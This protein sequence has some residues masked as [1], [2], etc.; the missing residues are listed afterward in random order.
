VS[1]A[2]TVNALSSPIKQ[3]RASRLTNEKTSFWIED[4]T[5]SEQG[6]EGVLTCECSLRFRNANAESWIRL[7]ANAEPALV[8]AG[9][10]L[11]GGRVLISLLAEMLRNIVYSL[12]KCGL[13][14]REERL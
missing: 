9:K 14:L 6:L 7:Q 4:A 12:K 11:W 13:L 5:E 2:Q 8:V 1:L 10:M 3:S